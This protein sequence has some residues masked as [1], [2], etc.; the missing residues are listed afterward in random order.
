MKKL[1]MFAV[2]IIVIVGAASAFYFLSRDD[3]AGSNQD[4]V[5]EKIQKSGKLVVGVDFSY[6]VMEFFDENNQPV[7]IDIDIINEIAKRL[8]VRAEIRRYVWD[9]LFAAVKSG[10]IDLA[11]SSITIT[12]Q[13]L[14]EMSFSAPYFNGGQA[15]VAKEDNAVILDLASLKDKKIGVQQDTTSYDEAAKITDPELIKQYASWDDAVLPG[16]IIFELKEGVIDA[17]IVD[18]IQA[19]ESVRKDAGLK[20]VGEPFT[21]EYYGIAAKLGNTA[22][23]ESVNSIL[24]DLKREGFL[25]NVKNKWTNR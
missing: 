20:I 4:P 21:Q 22:L 14:E 8:G 9:D 7:G 24:R 12:A 11:I 23:T 1:I 13:R 5:I 19:V 16:G 15:I 25:E 17:V 2:L 3:K 6:G 10:E 18:Y